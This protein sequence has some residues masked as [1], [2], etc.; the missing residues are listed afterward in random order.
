MPI[1]SPPRAGSTSARTGRAAGARG[2]RARTSC[3]TAPPPGAPPRGR[4]GR[5]G[6]SCT[7]LVQQ[8]RRVERVEADPG[9]DLLAR[10][11]R[12]LA[13]ERAQDLARGRRAP[14]VLPNLAHETGAELRGANPGAQVVGGVEARVHVGKE[15]LGRVADA[16]RGRG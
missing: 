5:R 4:R 7:E 6:Y 1:L 16:G 3:R 10:R 2:N 9:G 15:V 11:P 14:P 12:P 8:G 13:E